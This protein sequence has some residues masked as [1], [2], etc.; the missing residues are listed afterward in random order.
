VPG[1]GFGSGYWGGSSGVVLGAEVPAALGNWVRFVFFCFWR[2]SEFWELG[3]CFGFAAVCLEQTQLAHG[4]G[5]LALEG[6][7][8]ADELGEGVAVRRIV[9]E[10]PG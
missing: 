1:R 5:E 7:F 6:A 3:L 4:A 10:G 9:V 8:V 2:I